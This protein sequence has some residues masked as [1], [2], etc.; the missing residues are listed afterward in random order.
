MMINCPYCQ[1]DS[2]GNHES[3]CPLGVENQKAKE[4]E[5][6]L[7]K[8]F[9]EY[10]GVEKRLKKWQPIPSYGWICPVCGR[11]NAPFTSTCPC[12]HQKYEVTC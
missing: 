11:G 2:G 10:E 8:K 7:K 3:N 5:E 9:E 6:V 12:V 1:A 4:A